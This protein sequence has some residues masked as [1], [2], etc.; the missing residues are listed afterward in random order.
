MVEL[1]RPGRFRQDGLRCR[2]RWRVPLRRD[3]R[4]LGPRIPLAGGLDLEAHQAIHHL[5]CILDHVPESVRLTHV[6]SPRGCGF[7]ATIRPS[8]QSAHLVGMCA[9]IRALHASLR[10]VPPDAAS[11]VRRER[12]AADPA[13]HDLTRTQAGQTAGRFGRVDLQGTW[14]QDKSSTSG[15][16]LLRTS[17]R[18]RD[19]WRP[20][21]R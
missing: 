5:P 15:G 10:A 3:T 11:R 7:A 13:L 9:F 20:A 18:R 12:V 1:L 17:G 14:L 4:C 2:A 6:R 8:L 21:V 16:A 19:R